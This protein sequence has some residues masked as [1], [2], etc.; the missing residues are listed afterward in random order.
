MSPTQMITQPKPL[1]KSWN[2][3]LPILNFY[4]VSFYYEQSPLFNIQLWN[5]PCDVSSIVF[6]SHIRLALHIYR[7]QRS[8]GKVIFSQAS[9]ILFTGGGCLVLGGG[10]LPGGVTDPGGSA[11]GGVCSW[12]WGLVPGVPGGDPSPPGQLLLRA[13]RILLECILVIYVVAGLAFK[14][15]AQTL[16]VD[17]C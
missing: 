8:W 7:P 2:I 11:L 17:L 13:V 6:D 12:G 9:V 16:G 10:L 3:L 4:S 15:L 1:A 5:F 14:S